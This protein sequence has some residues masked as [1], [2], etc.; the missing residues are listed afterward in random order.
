MVSFTG[1][2]NIGVKIAETCAKDLK[3][4]LFELGGKGASLVFDGADIDAAV[5]GTA[6]TYTFHAGQICVAPTRLI[7]QRKVYDEVVTRLAAVAKAVKV[8]DPLAPDTVVGPVIT[9][10]HR[11]RVRNYIRA[12]VEEGGTIVA[13]GVESG[14]DAGFF[15]RPTLIADCSNTMKVARE[16]IFGP[17]VVAMPFDDEEEGIA[18][19]NDSDFGLYDYV[20]TGDAAQGMRVAQR[21]RC[22]NVGINTTGRNP[23]TPFGGFKKSGIGRDGGAFALHAY[24]EMQSIVWTS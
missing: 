17:V 14:L 9:S 13:G 6:S 5:M 1:S 10:A 24:T 20:W 11:E 21:L 3:R 4:V 2:T 8:G 22:G 16:E 19:S 18:L 23:E 12:G 7:V 15:V